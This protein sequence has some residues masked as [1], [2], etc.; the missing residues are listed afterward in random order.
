MI[1]RIY[2][3]I[4]NQSDICY[5]GSTI[6]QLKYRWQMHQTHYKSWLEN[7]HSEVGVYPY[8]KEHGITNF[9]MVLVKE[10]EVADK[11]HLYAIEQLWVNKFK[12][13]SVNK[14]NPFRIE[15]KQR[16]D[17]RY[18]SE[19]IEHKKELDKT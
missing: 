19:H 1:G 3:I 10:Y 15:T 11:K 18:R 16:Y 6:N 9:K 8:F 12:R 17:K 7:N 14:N 2:K 5:I 13:T 4:H